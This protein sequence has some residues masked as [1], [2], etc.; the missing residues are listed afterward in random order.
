MVK[1]ERKKKNTQQAKL[2]NMILINFCFIFF[3]YIANG[4]T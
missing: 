3:F 4:K 2:A 1:Y